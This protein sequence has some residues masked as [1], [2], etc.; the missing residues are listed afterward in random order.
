LYAYVKQNPWT[1]FDPEGLSEFAFGYDPA[2]LTDEERRVISGSDRRLAV[3]GAAVSVAV[4]ATIW[5][6]GAAAPYITFVLGNGTAATVTTGVVSGAV[7]GYAGNATANAL[8]GEPVN[9]NYDKA[10]LWGGVLGGVG[11]YV[12]QQVGKAVGAFKEGFNSVKPP[13]AA[14][15]VAGA[16]ATGAV[17]AAQ[18]TVDGAGNVVPVNA[19]GVPVDDFVPKAGAGPYARPAAAGPTAAQQAV[20]QGQPCVV[21]SKTAPKMVA[22]H[23]DPLV[24]EHYRTGT[25]D[26]AKQSSVVAVQ[27]HCPSCSSSQGGQLSAFSKRMKKQ[28]P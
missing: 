20:V 18:T 17:A 25:I 4:A 21:C 2:I 26:V 27:P 7:G 15:P 12:G 3:T 11:G 5:S 1:K 23:V 16:Q 22:D 19:Y 13:P 10:L 24:V 28:L 6:G 9:K 14:P 8:T